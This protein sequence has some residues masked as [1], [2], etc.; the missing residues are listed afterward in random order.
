V[1][2]DPLYGAEALAAEGFLPWEGEDVDGAILQTDH[3]AY[4]DLGPGDLPGV[5]AVV[6]GR[7][8]LDPQPFAAAGVALKRIGRP[9]EDQ[10]GPSSPS[11]A[12]ATRSPAR[13]SP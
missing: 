11:R 7:D 9:S 5:R 3:R 13:P 8:V 10:T 1:A 2:T 4:R 6:D 12:S